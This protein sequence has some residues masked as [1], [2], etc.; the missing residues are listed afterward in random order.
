MTPPAR[1]GKCSQ[2]ISETDDK[3]KEPCLPD[4]KILF[5]LK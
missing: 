3:Q 1:T 2:E 5:N 4:I